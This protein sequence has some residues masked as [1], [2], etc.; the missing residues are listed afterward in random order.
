MDVKTAT[1][2]GQ[3]RLSNRAQVQTVK[4]EVEVEGE[5]SNG[6]IIIASVAG[7]FGLEENLKAEL[8]RIRAAHAA[9][10]P[11]QGRLSSMMARRNLVL[12]QLLKL[13]SLRRT[14]QT[15]QRPKPNTTASL[16]YR[17]LWATQADKAEAGSEGD[18][19][20]AEPTDGT[21]EDD[22]VSE[23]GEQTIASVI[24]AQS[25][26]DMGICHSIKNTIAQLRAALESPQQPGVSEQHKVPDSPTTELPKTSEQVEGSAQSAITEESKAAKKSKTAQEPNPPQKREPTEQH[27]VSKQPKTSKQA[28]VTKKAKTAEQTEDT[29]QPEHSQQ[30][31]AAEQKSKA[32]KATGQSPATEQAKGTQQ[33]KDIEQPKITTQTRE[34]L[35]APETPK[36]VKHRRVVVP[37]AISL[38][39]MSPRKHSE[40][41]K[42]TK[43]PE[44][45]GPP[46]TPELKASEQLKGSEEQPECSNQPMVSEQPKTAEPKTAKQSEVTQQ[47]KTLERPKTTQRLEMPSQRK[48]TDQPLFPKH[49]MGQQKTPEKSKVTKQSSLDEQQ[50]A[51]EEA[52]VIEQPPTTKANE[53]HKGTE[54]PMAIEHANI[55][56]RPKAAGHID[57]TTQYAAPCRP[58]QGKGKLE[59]IYGEPTWRQAPEQGT[60]P[61][62]NMPRT[63]KDLLVDSV[64]D[65]P[66]DSVPQP[67]VG[68]GRSLHSGARAKLDAATAHDSPG[69]GNGA[70]PSRVDTDG[71]PALLEAFDIVG[72]WNNILDNFRNSLTPQEHDAVLAQT[73]HTLAPGSLRI[74]RPEELAP[75]SELKHV[76][77]ST[78]DDFQNSARGNPRPH[79]TGPAAAPTD[80]QT[81]S[82]AWNQKLDAFMEELPANWTFVRSDVITNINA[83]EIGQAP[84]DSASASNRT[85][86]NLTF[87]SVGSG[88][89]ATGY[90]N[91]YAPKTAIN[92]SANA[93]ANIDVNTS[94]PCRHP[95]EAAEEANHWPGNAN[96]RYPPFPNQKL[97]SNAAPHLNVPANATPGLS[98]PSRPDAASSNAQAHPANYQDT[99]THPYHPVHPAAPPGLKSATAATADTYNYTDSYS[100]FYWY[101]SENALRIQNT[102]STSC[103]SVNAQSRSQSQTLHLTAASIKHSTPDHSS[104]ASAALRRT[105]LGEYYAQIYGDGYIDNHPTPDLSQYPS[106]GGTL[107]R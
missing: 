56:Q 93:T 49:V 88:A 14:S 82:V 80:R 69:A 35:K 91:V 99:R 2:I 100:R 17:Q 57:Q 47:L 55:L 9:I 28:E 102:R 101:G 86:R 84:P 95:T 61:D 66:H 51:P 6:R 29:K 37:P 79:I 42:A 60:T 104:A 74:V 106:G 21:N 65:D 59:S 43:R 20:N 94:G 64:P 63:L 31:E 27:K 44:D 32:A 97:H 85:A 98:P 50:K 107:T 19:H 38:N 89:N 30:L 105:A 83:H 4:V 62:D 8:N 1:N 81:P 23:G 77:H 26:L 15:T 67:S 72:T 70:E 76:K 52:K 46:E 87:D 11:V 48:I 36:P 7:Y 78:L 103:S 54:N 68:H 53:A 18:E 58:S 33:S 41:P 96:T 75:E 45:S 24:H 10:S 13:H 92:V 39:F 22:Q 90:G 34:Q 40:I 71:C 25:T 12:I 5:G 73:G 16:K 3:L